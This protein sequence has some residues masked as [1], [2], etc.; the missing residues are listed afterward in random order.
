I[1]SKLSSDLKN[2]MKIT[3]S[4]RASD[5]EQSHKLNEVADHLIAY[6]GYCPVCANAALQYVG[7]ILSR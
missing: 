1:K 7:L 2:V 3:T 6:N 4:T 5:F